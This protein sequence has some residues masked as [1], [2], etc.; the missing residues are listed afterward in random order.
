FK[1][2]K[3]EKHMEILDNIP[4]SLDREEVLKT[5][6]YDKNKI[7]DVPD[8][9]ELID[10]A[11]SCAKPKAVFKASYI[12]V[13]NKNRINLDGVEFTSG[14]LAVNLKNVERVFP[15]VV[16]CGRELDG[17]NIPPDDMLKSYYLDAIK[18]II[19]EKAFDY[20]KD[21]I[22]DR[23]KTGK[24]SHMSPGS[25]EDWPIQEQTGLFSLLGNVQETIGVELTESLLM[26]PV[27]S[28]SGI[29]F[30]TETSFES[31]KLCPRANCRARR[32]RFDKKFA[33]KYDITTGSL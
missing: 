11:V 24:L 10:T 1:T 27:K 7:N 5:L 12:E 33:E 13:R 28:V 15:Y 18:E 26:V 16:T 4:L 14:V 17:I 32:A 30:P 19:L 2:K 23:F 9:H 29:H 20:L 31:C 8:I 25:L 6:H 22:K 21:F 3:A